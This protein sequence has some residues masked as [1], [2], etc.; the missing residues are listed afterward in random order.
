M[1]PIWVTLVATWWA[2]PVAAGAGVA[3][4]AGLRTR[5]TSRTRRLELDAARYELRTARADVARRRAD[6]QAARAE[7]ARMEAEQLSTRASASDV[8]A[9]RGALQASQSHRRA[10]AARVTAHRA[11]VRAARAA[12]P[13][14]RASR[15]AL[16][17]ARLRSAHDAV[18]ARWMAYET[19]PAAAVAH[20][21]MSDP[22]APLTAAFLRE[23]AR[24]HALRP[25]SAETP[26]T[27][28]DFAAYREA[29]RRLARAFDAAEQ[30]ALR[31]STGPQIA[32]P[33][34][35]LAQELVQNAQRAVARSADALGG[36]A[37]RAAARAAEG[38]DR[39][40]PGT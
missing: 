23:Q 6:V 15:D 40:R 19:D 18:I 7:V 5:R 29:V 9:A 34:N 31:R 4:W 2:V 1:D 36:A 32:G 26:M 8:A 16:P 11:D 10:A 30:H 38:R 22:Q 12:L 33:W 14:A 3:G 28:A 35:D 39:R 17:V 21:E 25:A 20:P 24:A 27:P 37:A 13:A